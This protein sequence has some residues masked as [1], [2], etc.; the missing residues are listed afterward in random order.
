MSLVHLVGV[1][2][3]YSETP[4]ITLF[5]K[6]FGW[7]IPKTEVGVQEECLAFHSVIMSGLSKSK[8]PPH[9]SIQDIVNNTIS[10][11]QA[12]GEGVPQDFSRFLA[13]PLFPEEYRSFVNRFMAL[14]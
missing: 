8:V 2:P 12:L 5:N 6:T 1:I 7:K 11:K 13:D 3:E 9:V 4:P 14:G 10:I